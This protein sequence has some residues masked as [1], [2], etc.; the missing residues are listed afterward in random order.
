VTTTAP[1]LARCLIRGCP[2]R[3][4]SGRDRL[5][6]EHGQDSAAITAA[7]LIAGF[8]DAPDD[9][10]RDSGDARLQRRS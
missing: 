8:M 6:R 7:D 10:D 1:L 2:V 9:D 5:C 4:T 3:F